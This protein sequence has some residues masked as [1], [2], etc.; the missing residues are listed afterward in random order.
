MAYNKT[1]WQN[2]PSTDTPINANNLN[3]IEQGIY[4]NSIDIESIDLESILPKGM[5]TTFAGDTAPTGWLVCDGSAV[6]RTTYRDLFL[7]VGTIYGSGDGSTTFNLPN[8]KGKVV[9]GVDTSD[10]NFDSLGETGGSKT[11]ELRA[12]IGAVG[13]NAQ[14]IGYSATSPVS[15]KT[16]TNG[17]GN[18]GSS[19]G[20]VSTINHSTVVVR[21]DGNNCSTLQPYIALNYIIKY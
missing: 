10:T 17:L 13:S 7:V 15:G 2:S 11:Q 12:L 21:S 1:N 16:Y 5:I 20:S 14:A 19:V 4:Q 9:T 6:S 18:V 3:K 8:L